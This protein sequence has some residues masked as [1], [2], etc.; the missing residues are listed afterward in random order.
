MKERVY[1][2]RVFFRWA[3]NSSSQRIFSPPQFRPRGPR[4][5]K[6]GAIA[7]IRTVLNYFLAREID[8]E[9]EAIEAASPVAAE[10]KT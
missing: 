8:E 1:Y 2:W 4:V 6:L 7:A 3:S 9:K 10:I 5:G